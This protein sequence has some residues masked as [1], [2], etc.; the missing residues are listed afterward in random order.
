MSFAIPAAPPKRPRDRTTPLEVGYTIALK[1]VGGTVAWGTFEAKID[2]RGERGEKVPSGVYYIRGKSS[3]G[4]FKHLV[5]IL[6]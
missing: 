5:T 1:T 3:E 2:G 4:A 6:K